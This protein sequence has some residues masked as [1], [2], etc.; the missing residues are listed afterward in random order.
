MWQGIWARRVAAWQWHHSAAV[1][2]LGLMPARAMR[3]PPTSARCCR[4]SDLSS[5]RAVLGYNPTSYA[6]VGEKKVTKFLFK[7]LN[8]LAFLT[9]NPWCVIEV[10]LVHVAVVM[11]ARQ[12]PVAGI[13]VWE[14]GNF[15]TLFMM[16][17]VV[18]RDTMCGEGDRR[19]FCLFPWGARQLYKSRLQRKGNFTLSE[20]KC[21]AVLYPSY[22][23]YECLGVLGLGISLFLQSSWMLWKLHGKQKKRKTFYFALHDVAL[24]VQNKMFFL[25][26]KHCIV[27]LL[28]VILILFLSWKGIDETPLSSQKFSLLPGLLSFLLILSECLLWFAP[29]RP[30]LP[31]SPLTSE[32]NSQGQWRHQ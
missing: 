30:A 5:A 21:S 11:S 19:H 8:Q 10:R 9:E 14:E 15:L 3:S 1:R 22:S 29:I 2:V 16:D 12:K 17:P 7:C 13:G 20:V 6:Q 24:V 31:P 26:R 23:S 25:G 28:W 18:T 32:V 4:G 27:C